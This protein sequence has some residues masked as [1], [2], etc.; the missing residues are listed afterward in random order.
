M[1]GDYIVVGLWFCS[2]YKD[3][4]MPKFQCRKIFNN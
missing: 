2:S 4:C 3:K 1:K